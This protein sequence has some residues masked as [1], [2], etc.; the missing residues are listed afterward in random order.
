MTSRHRRKWLKRRHDSGLAK[1]QLQTT[2]KKKPREGKSGEV[3]WYRE[4]KERKGKE[5]PSQG[6][7][8]RWKRTTARRRSLGLGFNGLTCH[9]PNFLLV[10][11]SDTHTHALTKLTGC[12][13]N[14]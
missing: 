7:I 13:E 8:K 11:A 10:L 3:K 6:P 14:S 1:P 4:G 9:A 2:A 5:K 12:V